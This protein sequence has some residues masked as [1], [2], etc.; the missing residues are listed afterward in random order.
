VRSAKKLRFQG[1]LFL[2]DCKNEGRTE[3]VEHLF[4][5]LKALTKLTVLGVAATLDGSFFKKLTGAHTGLKFSA[6]V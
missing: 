6:E 1:V 5:E 3:L 4:E 2:K